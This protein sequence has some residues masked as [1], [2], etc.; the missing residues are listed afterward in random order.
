MKLKALVVLSSVLA[1]GLLLAP[2][3]NA[4]FMLDSSSTSA[5]PWYAH[6]IPAQSLR[7]DVLGG[8]GR[9]VTV[10]LMPDIRG[11]SGV[12]TSLTLRPDI[13]DVNGGGSS[14]ETPIVSTPSTGFAWTDAGIGALTAFALTLLVAASLLVTRRT[15]TAHRLSI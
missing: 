8:I 11:G 10:T 3:A 2:A 9:P 15:R 1:I 4:K 13:R 6:Y 14:V 12:S 5:T 7:P